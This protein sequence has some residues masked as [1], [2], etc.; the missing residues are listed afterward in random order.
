VS[1][2]GGHGHSFGKIIPCVLRTIQI[3]I[4]ALMQH[5]EKG[6]KELQDTVRLTS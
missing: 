5:G 4:R 6:L 3:R 1:F 2:V